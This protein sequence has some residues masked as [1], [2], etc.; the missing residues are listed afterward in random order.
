M[1]RAVTFD[2]WDTIVVD[3]SDE[4]KRAAAGLPAKTV[5][6][7]Q[8]FV[9]C[10]K[11]AHPEL[12]D[13]TVARAFEHT[14]ERFLHLWKVE[15][16]T[17][18]VADRLTV[19]IQWLG[20]ARPPGF[21]A[22]VGTFEQMEVLHPPDLVPGIRE[23][24]E[25]LAE[26]YTLGIISD[27]IVT[28]GRGLRAILDG[29]GLLR[30]FRAPVFSDEVGF[31][32]PHPRVFEAACAG[33]GVS[34]SSLLHIGDREANDVAG[35]QAFGAKAILYTGSVDRGSEDTRADA[36]CAHYEHLPTLVEG[37]S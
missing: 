34:P 28:P 29:Y 18:T 5:A 30:F 25:R 11:G 33:L 27:A 10:I 35:P 15:H 8:A 36:V 14:Q 13:A 32:K 19:G 22:L 1:I 7:R 23:A 3:D 4:P 2:F 9:D 21:D 12:D 6:R 16:R 20:I 31:S 24:L 17:P 37:L 26:D